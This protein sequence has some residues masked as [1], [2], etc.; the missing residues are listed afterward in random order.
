MTKDKIAYIRLD[1][2]AEEIIATKIS[3]TGLN[4]SAAIRMI[5]REWAEMKKQF[6]TIPIKGFVDDVGRVVYVA[7]TPADQED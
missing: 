5:I 4:Q 3:E 6:V 1:K 7:D 2:E